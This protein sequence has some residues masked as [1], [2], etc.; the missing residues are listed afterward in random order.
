[1]ISCLSP[2]ALTLDQYTPHEYFNHYDGRMGTLV[3]AVMG[4]VHKIGQVI[5]RNRT[6]VA[7][8][9]CRQMGFESGNLIRGPWLRSN[10][11]RFSRLT[12]WCTGKEQTILG[13]S[14]VDTFVQ[15]SE[16]MVDYFICIIAQESTSIERSIYIVQQLQNK[17]S[18]I[19]MID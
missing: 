13:C 3:I 19:V 18:Q 10:D 6:A 2:V 16:I 15:K 9:V 7:Q 8:V 12:A 4:V 1:M 14:D 5:S 11:D 17:T